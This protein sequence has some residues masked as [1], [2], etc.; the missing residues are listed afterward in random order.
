[1]VELKFLDEKET[2][3]FFDEDEEQDDEIESLDLQKNN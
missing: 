3:N 2:A 1:M